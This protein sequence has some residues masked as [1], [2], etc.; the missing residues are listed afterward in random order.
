MEAGLVLRYRMLLHPSL[1]LIRDRK[2]DNHMVKRCFVGS[3]AVDWLTRISPIVHGRFH[4]IAMLQALLEEGVIT[5][6]KDW[7]LKG[8]NLV[9]RVFSAPS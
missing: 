2:R 6:G 5:H 7:Y 9:P 1:K 4:A 8:P 3:E